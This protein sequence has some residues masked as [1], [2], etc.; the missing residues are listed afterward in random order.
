LRLQRLHFEQQRVRIDTRQ[1]HGA[2]HALTLQRI[3]PTRLQP[4]SPGG[5]RRLLI[6]G[7]VPELGDWAGTA[8]NVRELQALIYR[9]IGIAAVATELFGEENSEIAQSDMHVLIHNLREIQRAA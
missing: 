2:Q 6:A 9:E 7:A 4:A 5:A 3:P 1:E 8:L